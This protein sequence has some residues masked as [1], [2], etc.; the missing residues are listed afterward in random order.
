MS[1]SYWNTE[2]DGQQLVIEAVVGFYCPVRKLKG[3]KPGFQPVEPVQLIYP[4]LW[5][6]FNRI[7]TFRIFLYSFVT[8][9]QKPSVIS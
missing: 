1:K 2:Q 7:S 6:K 8:N 9:K 3:I 5:K 4:R